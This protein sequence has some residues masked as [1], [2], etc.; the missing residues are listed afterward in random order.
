[1]KTLYKIKMRKA[2]SRGLRGMPNNVPG[3]LG[4]IFHR[5]GRHVA[6][7]VELN[8]VKVEDLTSWTPQAVAVRLSWPFLNEITAIHENKV[9]TVDLAVFFY[10]FQSVKHLIK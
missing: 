8:Y 1:M 6:K 4:R 10:D 2:F 5:I 3:F 9:Y 7:G